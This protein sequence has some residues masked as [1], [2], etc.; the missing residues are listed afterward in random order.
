MNNRITFDNRNRLSWWF[1]RL[2][3]NLPV[4][5]TVIIPYAG[6]DLLH[7]LDGEIPIDFAAMCVRITNAGD[8]LGWPLFLRTDYLSGKHSWKDTCHVPGPD[9][10]QSHVTKLVEESAMADIFGFPTDRWIARKLIPTIAMFSAFHGNMPIVKER[11]YFVQDAQVTCH[12]PYWPEEAFNSR[13][14]Q[15]GDWKERLGEMNL[16]EDDEVR[17]LSKLSS[18]IGA[19]LGGAWSIDWLWSEP[20]GQWFLTDMAEAESSYHW[21]GCPVA[22]D[23]D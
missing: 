7:L 23:G 21:P 6:D 10:V 22:G 19:A 4:P 16:E 14:I 11:R 17:M 8:E 18:K 12:H 1:P 3:C 15:I 2:P 9:N 5:K 20:L 13:S